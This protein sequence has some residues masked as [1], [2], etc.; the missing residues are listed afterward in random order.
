MGNLRKGRRQAAPLFPHVQCAYCKRIERGRHAGTNP[1][2][3]VFYHDE[4]G[5]Y[6]TPE[7]ARAAGLDPDLSAAYGHGT[8]DAFDL[9]HAYGH[10]ACDACTEQE[11]QRYFAEREARLAQ[12]APAIEDRDE[13]EE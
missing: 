3:K 1:G 2:R 9:E 8:D 12:Q 4:H 11:I 7:E 6:A 10:V 13:G 5:T